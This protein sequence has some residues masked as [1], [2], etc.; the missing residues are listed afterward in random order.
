MGTVKYP[1]DRRGCPSFQEGT[2]RQSGRGK[3]R[4]RH[5]KEPWQQPWP[6]EWDWTEAEGYLREKPLRWEMLSDLSQTQGESSRR[7]IRRKTCF[8]KSLLF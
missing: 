4:S 2:Q 8:R 5:L 1:S 7:G 3:H 6:G